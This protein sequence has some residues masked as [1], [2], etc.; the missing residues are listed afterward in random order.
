MNWALSCVAVG[1]AALIPACGSAELSG[2]PSIRL[3][4][5]LCAGCGMLVCEDRSSCAMLVAADGG[6]AYL[7][8]DDLGC[9]LDYRADH[10]Q[11][12]VVGTF[13]HDYATAQWVPAAAAC[14]LSA[15]PQA[16]KTP[17]GS[18]I[19]AFSSRE[20][21]EA[22]Q[23]AVGGALLGFDGLAGLRRSRNQADRTQPPGP[24]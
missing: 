13:V 1:V 16:L 15:P 18:G 4:R 24:P 22:Q 11:V 23:G 8:F 5:D 7:V 14:Y 17:M 20:Q 9:L 2:P 10:P 12:G 6:R 3:G 19:V 21:A